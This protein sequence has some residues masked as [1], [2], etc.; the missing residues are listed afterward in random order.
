VPTR[1][2]LLR[3]TAPAPDPEAQTPGTS[4]TVWI[5]RPLPDPTPPAARLSPSFA[6]RLVAAAHNA[7][8]DWTLVLGL[9]RADGSVGSVPAAR[10]GLLGLSARIGET[11][12]NGAWATAL[13]LSGSTVI[14]DRAQ[15]LSRYYRAAGLK[16]LVRGLEATKADLAARL[17]RDPRVHIYPGGR[18]DIEAGRVDVRVLAVIAYLA[19][20]FGEVTVSCLISG[21]RLYARPGVVSA[22]I[23][24]RAVDIGSLGGIPI[25]GNQL[26]GGVTEHAIR[27][28]LLLPNELQPRQVISLLGLG[29]P[30]FPLADHVDHIHVGY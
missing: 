23:F 26:P 13:A 8:V 20:S 29:G 18:G 27:D 25:A 15:A 5:N 12:A 10:G 9:L 4:A 24:G 28:I 17:L 2:L 19:E 14:A 7:G 11:G 1:Q 6:R 3:R 21:H 30:S 16:A 22:H